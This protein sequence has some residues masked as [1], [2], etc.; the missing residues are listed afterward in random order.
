[1]DTLDK[2]NN[3]IG[4][5]FLH[6]YLECSD[7]IQKLVKDLINEVILS[8][9]SDHDE[10]QMAMFSIADALFPNPHKGLHGMDLFESESEA[11]CMEPE[12]AAIVADF[13]VQELT[14]SERL[15]SV[16]DESGMT[17]QELADAVGL[18]Q[19]AIANI[20]SRNCRPQQ[21]TVKKIADALGLQPSDLWPTFVE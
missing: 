3:I 7:E 10:K 6:A 9:E 2:A 1:M 17:Q 12:L 13:D 15:R 5:E 21:R 11:A 4:I 8:D 19:S 18:R 16:L 14:F 20:L